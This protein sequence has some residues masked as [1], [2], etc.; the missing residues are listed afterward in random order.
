LIAEA[1]S[2]DFASQL[3]LAV[4][5]NIGLGREDVGKPFDN[6]A[7]DLTDAGLGDVVF[8]RLGVGRGAGDVDGFVNFEI[9]LGGWK[10]EVAGDLGVGCRRRHGRAY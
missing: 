2:R 10:A 5:G 9:T 1:I 6:P 8:G 4:P 7:D 3:G